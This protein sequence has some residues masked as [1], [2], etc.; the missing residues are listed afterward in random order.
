M[1]SAQVRR[2]VDC[3]LHYM[4]VEQIKYEPERLTEAVKKAL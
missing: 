1:D 4:L 3:M 2:E